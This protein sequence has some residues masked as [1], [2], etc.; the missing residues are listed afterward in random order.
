MSNN[1]EFKH[2][3]EN[4]SERNGYE[5]INQCDKEENLYEEIDFCNIPSNILLETDDNYIN[6]HAASLLNIR[7]EQSTRS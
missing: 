3:N 6:V 5:N 2:L 7:T 1:A 4:E